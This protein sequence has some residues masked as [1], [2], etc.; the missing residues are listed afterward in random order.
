[1]LKYQKLLKDEW[2]SR[3]GF[4]SMSVPLGDVTKMRK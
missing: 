3:S 1:M 2:K 4:I